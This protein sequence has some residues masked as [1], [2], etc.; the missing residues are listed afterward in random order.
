MSKREEA[1]GFKRCA[2]SLLF[3]YF[4][5]VKHRFREGTLSLSLS[6][7]SPSKLFENKSL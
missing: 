3:V 1:V 6:L 7:F 4:P 2:A 5:M